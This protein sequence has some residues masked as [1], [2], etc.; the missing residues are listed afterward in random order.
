[1]I[2]RTHAVH[3]P[4]AAVF[5]ALVAVSVLLLSGCAHKQ[6]ANPVAPGAA[7]NPVGALL[8]AAWQAP[9]PQGAVPLDGAQT[10][11]RMNDPLLPALV[12]A[13]QQASPSLASAAA[14]IERARAS[15]VAAGAALLPAVDA[16]GSASRV[17]TVPK[18]AI[19]ESVSAGAQAGWELDLFGGVAA[20]RD[21]A[22]ARLQAAQAGWHGARL[23]VAAETASS[24][25][26]LR[27]CEAQIA[28]T[29]LDADS[30]AQTSRLT[31]LSA[32]AGFT[33]P[34]DAALAR[35]SAA[36]ARNALASQRAAC[37]TLLKSLVELTDLAEPDLRQRLAA[38][39]ARVPRP[40]ALAV[41]DTLPASLLARRPD[42]A[43]A[44]LGVL[45]AAGDRAQTQAR[46]KP[47]VSLSGSLNFGSGRAGGVTATGSVWSL[48]PLQISFPLFDGGARAAASVAAQANYEEALAQYRSL[49]RRAVREVEAA[50]VALQSSNEREAD[51]QAAAQDFELSL[52]ATEARQKGGLASLFELEAARRNAVAAQSALIDLQRERAAAWIALVRALGGGWSADVQ[53]SSGGWSADV[54]VSSGGWSADVLTAAR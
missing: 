30:R 35:A 7:S 44:E 8:P 54:Q 2:Q 53:V 33:P 37:D 6:A 38:G 11:S 26:Q 27:A 39:T 1:V 21:A 47:Q 34:A 17:R 16:V 41:A 13:A 18:G 43:D 10:W 24:Y 32:Q 19:T 28:Q 22:Q 42:L 5:T 23:S 36:Q 20:G 40:Q 29:Q 48:G 31:G 14:R 52:K 3:A 4:G 12:A 50:L 49:A 46:E 51:A 15:R 9:L 25:V 45:A